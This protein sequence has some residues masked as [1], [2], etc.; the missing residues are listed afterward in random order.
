MRT[1]AIPLLL[2]LLATT[3]DAAPRAK[4]RPAPRAPARTPVQ[5]EA[6]RHFKS[7]V[8]LFKE[9]KYAEALAEFERAYEI[10]PHPLVLYNIAITAQGEAS[11]KDVPSNPACQFVSS[12]HKTPL[13]R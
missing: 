12:T 11:V 2:G 6:D 13:E 8:A 3:A 1:L 9:A 10:A 7:G 5:K 4:K